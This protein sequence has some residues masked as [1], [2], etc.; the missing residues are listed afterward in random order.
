MSIATMRSAPASRAP[1]TMD[2]PTP[3]QPMT[4][5]VAP[6]GTAAVLRT[7][8]TPVATAQPTRHSTSRGAS[9]RTLMAPAAGTT[10]CSAKEEVP[11]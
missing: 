7:A 2:S 4:T 1:W 8:P 10:A 5:T 11:R 3:P 9:L 6:G